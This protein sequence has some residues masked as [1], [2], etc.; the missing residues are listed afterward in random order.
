MG[1]EE[2]GFNRVG[3]DPNDEIDD[4]SRAE[5][6]DITG[7]KVSDD[8]R[9]LRCETGGDNGECW[10]AGVWTVLFSGELGTGREQHILDDCG[11]W[12]KEP[13]GASRAQLADDEDAVTV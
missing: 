10:E 13:G 6:E 8:T 9:V 4:K 5:T 1:G 7:Q 2:E 11:G 12:R 3:G